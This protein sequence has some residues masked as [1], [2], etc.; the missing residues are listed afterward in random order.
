MDGLILP[1]APE[2]GVTVYDLNVNIEF[3]DELSVILN[4]QLP[5]PEHDAA[6]PVPPDQPLNVESVVGV[7]VRVTIVP[8]LYVSE[9]SLPQFIPVAVTV[10]VPVPDFVIVKV[11]DVLIN[12]AVTVVSAFI[13]IVQIPV[14]LQPGSDQPVKLES[15]SAVAVR[16]IVAPEL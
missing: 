6:V 4:I 8:E 3:S 5:A 13:V 12:I 16:V 7:P 9:Q 14:P 15:K 2:D 10:P 11:R 1:L